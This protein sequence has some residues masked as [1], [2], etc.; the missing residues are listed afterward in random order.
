MGS[1]IGNAR[2]ELEI[3]KMQQRAALVLPLVLEMNLILINK[4]FFTLNYQVGFFVCDNISSNIEKNIHEMA[5]LIT[6]DLT[7][8][9]DGANTVMVLTSSSGKIK[10]ITPIWGRKHN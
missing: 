8:A 7:E 2:P 6:N 5:I 1:I 4:S 10:T 9:I 3:Q